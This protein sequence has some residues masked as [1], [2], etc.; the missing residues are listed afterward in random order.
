M[1]LAVLHSP[2][3]WR[4]RFG[5]P[6][7]KA[8]PRSALTVGNFDGIHLGHQKIL[9]GVVGRARAT[10]ALAAAVTF[11]PHP[12]KRLRPAEA[13]PLI[14]T[15]AQRLAGLEQMGLD[16]ALVLKFDDELSRLPPEGFARGILLEQLGMESILVGE[17]FRFGHRQAGDVAMLAELGRKL[18]FHV[19][20]VPPVVVRGEVVSSTAIRRAINEGRV[21]HAARL[22]GR[23]FALSGEVRPGTGQGSRL[24]VPTLNLFTEQELLPKIGVYATETKVA[25]NLYRSATNVGVRPTFD[26]RR[27]IVESHL[28]DFSDKITSG[29]MEIRFWKRLRDERKFSGPDA[30]RAQIM[31]DFASARRFLQLLSR[32]GCSEPGLSPIRDR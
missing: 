10:G 21:G 25:G 18:G 8:G 9:L 6:A 30:L 14:A 12:L 1:P 11:D 17:N 28:F 3:E 26:G 20:I 31:K 29:T 19:E 2:A 32:A 24:V 13:P 5:T 15:L 7:L 27:L 22:L 4:A 16:A 23:P